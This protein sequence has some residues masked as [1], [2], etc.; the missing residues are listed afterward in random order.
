METNIPEISITPDV[1]FQLGPVPINNAVLTMFIITFIILIL[2]IVIRASV[3]VVPGRLQLTFEAI[4][5][6]LYTNL[7]EA[8][9]CEKTARLHTPMIVAVFL[10]ILIS[11]QFMLIPFV[12]SIMM[13]GDINLFRAPSTHYA[14]PFTFAVIALVLAHLIAFFT[15]P[16][17]HLDNFFRVSAILKIRSIKDVPM[18]LLEVFLG[19]LDIIGEIGKLLS[20][21]FRLFGNMFAGEV[22]VAVIAGLSV[23]TQY[24]VPIPFYF[25]S[26]F[27]G[28]I[29]AL[30]FAILTV[31][32]VANM[33]NSVKETN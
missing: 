32:F 21:S 3:S 8:H 6:F 18:A 2:G 5:N 23:Y 11:N 27:S 10:F 14:M 16:L 31:Y 13:D 9:R 30:V 28:F 22:M 29:Q 7:K 15:S 33:A 4:I 25:L 26:M 20:L 19:L 24:L 12:Q 17:K 1:L